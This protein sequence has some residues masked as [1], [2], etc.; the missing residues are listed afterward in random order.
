MI[1]QVRVDVAVARPPT[2]ANTRSAFV[3]IAGDTELDCQLAATHM[4]M[5]ST[6]CVMPVAT[7]ILT[8]T[9]I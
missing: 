2:P 3:T 5:A 9:D 1:A 8:L 6:R 4:V 7:E